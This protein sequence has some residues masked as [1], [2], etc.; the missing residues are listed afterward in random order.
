MYSLSCRHRSVVQSTLSVISRCCIY[1]ESWFPRSRV[2]AH[3]LQRWWQEGCGSGPPLP[4]VPAGTRHGAA[5]RGLGVPWTGGREALGLAGGRCGNLASA[6]VLQPACLLL[7]ETP[8]SPGQEHFQGFL[9]TGHPHVVLT[10]VHGRDWQ[11]SAHNK[12]SPVPRCW[13]KN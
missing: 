5:L 9:C 6:V 13:A 10:D 1:T 3:H 12:S 8:A 2:G 7:R 11:G 4:A